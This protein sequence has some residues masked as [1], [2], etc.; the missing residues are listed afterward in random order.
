M[1]VK[2]VKTRYWRPGEDY[3]AAI[4]DNTRRFL[5]D[6]DVLVVSEKALSVAKGNVVDEGVVEAGLLARILVVFWMRFLWGCFLGRVCH[7]RDETLARLRNYP[8]EEGARHKQTA[9]RSAGFMQALKYGSEGGIDMSNL[10]LSYVCL[11][12]KSPEEEAKR[13]QRTLEERLGKKI[14]VVIADT[15]STFSYRNFHFTSR[16][17]PVKGIKS[18]GGAFSFIAGR[19]LRLRQR[20]TPLAV[21][22]EEMGVEEALNV[23]EAVHHA[24]GYGAGRTVWDMRRRFDVGFSRV[25]WEMLGGVDHFPIVIIRRS[26]RNIDGKRRPIP[27]DK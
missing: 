27:S 20:A 24:R 1:K 19:A 3:L 14:T 23:A 7:F 2:V 21:A 18:F 26:K 22:G 11:P 25:T 12:L 4:A 9:L 8:L 10:P 6:G 13:I 17:S 16:P 5:R 15:D